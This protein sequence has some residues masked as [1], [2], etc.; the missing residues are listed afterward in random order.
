M[1]ASEASITR[2]FWLKTLGAIANGEATAPL[3]AKASIHSIQDLL[4]FDPA[5]GIS[6]A[7]MSL[8]ATS[9]IQRAVALLQT[10]MV[11]LNEGE[12]GMTLQWPEGEEGT[13]YISRIIAHAQYLRPAE[14]QARAALLAARHA[15]P[16]A[17][18]ASMASAAATASSEKSADDVESSKKLQARG[19]AL[20]DE[21]RKIFPSSV[22]EDIDK[23]IKYTK[24]AEMRDTYTS[25][26]PTIV[27]LGDFSLEMAVGSGKKKE[28][29][30]HMGKTYE[31]HDP[32]DKTVEIKDHTTLLRMIERR[33]A[34]RVA[35]FAFDFGADL[36]AKKKEP[37]SYPH[38]LES[39]RVQY[40]DKVD[41]QEA[42]VVEINAYCTPEGADREVDAMKAFLMRNPH[43]PIS[44][45]LNVVDVGVQKAI[46]QHQQR[47]HSFDAAVYQAC[48]K[49]PELYSAALLAESGGGEAD[50]PAASAE[51]G[52]EVATTTK[53]RGGKRTADEQSA[54]YEKRLAEQQKQIANLKTGKKGKGGGGGNGYG[55][56]GGW[57][58]T[59]GGG[60]W[61]QWAGGDGGK[62][63]GKG[64]G[65]NDGGKGG[66]G[67]GGKGGIACPDYLCKAFNFSVGGCQLTNCNRKHEC[68]ACGQNHPYRSNH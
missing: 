48:V 68:P 28:T 27:P 37:K 17:T 25:G 32:A 54:V 34:C 61:Q 57:A 3:F 10:R 29:Y 9:A 14:M 45:V 60:Q 31:S 15:M 16:A 39:S 44:K 5:F 6:P 64:G 63:G 38:T 19:K 35:A 56:G 55:Y 51:Q 42:R 18:N 12:V 21:A 13:E 58:D 11:G 30:V 41:G 23:R 43:A 47:E 22:P 36:A 53:K 7:M 67:G 59:R 46:A 26:I 66:K 20:Y 24:V 8:E 40:I 62:G 50:A 33:S 1:T 2:D 52:E 4:A 65:W 49:S